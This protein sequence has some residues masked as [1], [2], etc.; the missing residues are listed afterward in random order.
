MY[1]ITGKNGHLH[2]KT[3]FRMIKIL[4]VALF[5]CSSF[6]QQDCTNIVDNA[7]R[8]YNLSPL[9][10]EIIEWTDPKKGAVYKASIC[11][12]KFPSCGE[13]D[14]AGI[15]GYCEEFTKNQFTSC[16]GMFKE[17]SAISS[18]SGGILIK[19][20]DGQHGQQG[21]VTILCNPTAGKSLNVTTADFGKKM[22]FESAF[23]CPKSRS[24]LSAGSIILIIFVVGIVS[25][26]I[27]GVIFNKVKNDASGI[28][29]I[30]NL[31]IWYT[32]ATLILQGLVFTKNKTLALFGKS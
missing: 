30:P 13:C 21:S 29:L 2:W 14:P 7:K 8:S 9:I 25:Y 1:H 11:E 27:I 16:V 6:G 19:Y 15:A 3:G 23:A 24:G 20:L 5:V 10:G 4:I 18:E 28:E 31:Y 26:L 17:V 12:N 32:L 22:T